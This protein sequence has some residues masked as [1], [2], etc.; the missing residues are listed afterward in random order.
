MSFPRA[1]D[2]FRVVALDASYQKV[3]EYTETWPG[4]MERKEGK[5]FQAVFPG[6]ISLPHPKSAFVNFY[7]LVNPSFYWVLVSLILVAAQLVIVR[8]RKIPFKINGVICA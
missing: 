7:V 1:E 2:F 6:Q 4:R 5:I 8:K 3:D